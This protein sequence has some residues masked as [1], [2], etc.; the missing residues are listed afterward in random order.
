MSTI[1]QDQGAHEVKSHEELLREQALENIKRRRDFKAHALAYVLVNA[2]L[3]VIWA[4]T[5]SAHG[6]PIFPWPIIPLAGWG[7]GLGMHAWDTYRRPITERDVDR[8][9]ERLRAT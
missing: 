7:I 1:V 2:F 4:V 6:S 5:S 9:L 3:W 8:E